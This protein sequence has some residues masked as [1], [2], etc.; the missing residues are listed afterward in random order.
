MDEIWKDIEGYEGWYSISNFG[1]VRRDKPEHNTFIGKILKNSIS[2]RGYITTTLTKNGIMKSFSVHSL[3]AKHFIGDRPEDY[4]INHKDCNKTNNHIYNLE[5]VTHKEN[6]IH[7]YKNGR[8]ISRKGTK[9]I[10]AKLTEEIVINIRKQY[11][12]GNITQRS[13]A[14]KYKVSYSLICNI[15]SKKVWNHI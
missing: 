4:T 9:S 11:S 15:I 14:K 2:P 6:V 3:V 5:Y 8:C 13:I 1:N 7:S 10:L 12:I